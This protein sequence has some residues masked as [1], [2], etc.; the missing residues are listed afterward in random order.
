MKFCSFPAKKLW[1][2]KR[3][4]DFEKIMIAS[5]LYKDIHGLG[6][7]ELR[8][9]LRPFCK[10]STT[11]IQHNVHAV[12]KEL[13]RWGE[14]VI[15]PGSLKKLQRAASR[16]TRPDFCSDVTLWI[17]STDFRIKGKKSVH[18]DKSCWSYKCKGPGRRLL[19]ICDGK[20]VTQWVSPMHKPTEYD[21]DLLIFYARELD[22]KFKGCHMIGDNHFRKATDLLKNIKLIT[23]KAKPSH[24]ITV[25]GRRVMAQLSDEET[26]ANSVIAGVRGRIEAP[27]GW[28]KTNFESFY[29]PFYEDRKQHHCLIIYALAIHRY[30]FQ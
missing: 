13:K 10:I 19:T 18:K 6:Y 20:G 29:K 23:N 1:I 11:S 28:L 9:I 22:E 27:Y 15:V 30:K 2:L 26:H 25:N 8:K 21:G 16:T 7:A 17:D 14:S 24:R 5:T 4:P 12:R 3:P